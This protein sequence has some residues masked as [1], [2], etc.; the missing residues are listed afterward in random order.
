MLR[1]NRSSA[2]VVA[3]HGNVDSNKKMPV[4]VEKTIAPTES[5]KI[6]QVADKKSDKADKRGNNGTFSMG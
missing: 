3:F 2:A 1:R 4:A 6:V 5:Q